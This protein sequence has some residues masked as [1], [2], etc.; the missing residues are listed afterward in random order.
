MGN[1]LNLN[2][3]ANGL[4]ASAVKTKDDEIGEEISISI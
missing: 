2:C 1:F 3:L 4:L